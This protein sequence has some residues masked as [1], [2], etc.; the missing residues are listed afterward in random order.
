MVGIT[1]IGRRDLGFGIINK[2][3]MFWES[4]GSGRWPSLYFSQPKV[5]EDLFYDIFILYHVAVVFCNIGG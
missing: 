2:G 4:T 1:I 5:L 3:L